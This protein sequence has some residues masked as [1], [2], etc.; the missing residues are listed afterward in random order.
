MIRFHKM[1][2]SQSL[3]WKDKL[4]KDAIASAFDTFIL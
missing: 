2:V 4:I 3:S 1:L